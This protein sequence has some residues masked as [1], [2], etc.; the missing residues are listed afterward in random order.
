MSGGPKCRTCARVQTSDNRR[1]IVLITDC[2]IH[3]QPVEM[4]KPQ[5]LEL[6][7]K[8]R[9][10]FDQI[11]EFCRS[12]KAFLKHLD[13]CGVDRAA[14]INYVAPEVIG[15][16]HGVNQFVADYVK[17]DPKRLISCG[18]LHPRHTA[19]VLA[20]MEQILRLGIRMIK[21]HPPHQLLF[22]NDYL[23]GVKELE[24]IYRAAEANS[25][26]VMF[27]TGT[28]VFPGARN[29]YGDP[30]YV[31]DVAVDFPRL[32][33]LLAHGGRPL[34]MQTAFFLVRRHS[35]VYLDISGIPPKTLLKYFPRLEEIAQKT[36]F[37]T[38]WPGPGVPDIRKNLDEFRALPL[39][40]DVRQQ[41]LSKTAA[42]IWPS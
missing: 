41:I 13:V 31:D 2:H 21:I 42:S 16:T 11:V 26:P 6:M 17:T 37:G 23:T 24:I 25:V 28:S 34:W 22:P 12:P 20:D 3:I 33:I 38:D 5:A 30:I 8:K 19:N 18:S 32:K 35:N 40:E 39:T 36:L 27:H 29:K 4:F 10:D 9:P 7:K 15:F 14:L 1:L